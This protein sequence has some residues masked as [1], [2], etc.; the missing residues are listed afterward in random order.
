MNNKNFH[1][2][3][4]FFYAMIFALIGGCSSSS[5]SD[6]SR[7]NLQFQAHPQINESAPLKVRV[8]LLKSDADFMS[9]DFYSL[10]NNASATL[11]AN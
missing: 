1:R 8:L 10:Q 11:G 4:L 3:W 5:H 9:S 2:L 6:P 7:Y